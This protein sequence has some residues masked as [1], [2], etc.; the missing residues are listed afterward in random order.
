MAETFDPSN[1]P[2][3]V[4]SFLTERHLATLTLQR[5]DGRPH[6]TPVGFTFDQASGLARVITWSD[7]WKNKH[8]VRRPDHEVAI[9]QV[10]GGQ[11]L[12]L[13]GTA[14]ATSDPE[15]AAEG[16]RRYAERYRQ[17]KDRD[18]RVV[19]EITVGEIIGTVRQQD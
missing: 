16:V 8:V 14:V 1:L 19:I 15:R 17:P 9:C 7:S 6:V 3:H 4:V 13:Y 10:D 12:T 11:W 2:P 5:R 18:D